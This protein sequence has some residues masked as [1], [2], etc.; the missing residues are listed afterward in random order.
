MIDL[1]S[2]TVFDKVVEAGSFTGAAERL[3]VAKAR[4]SV[5][6]SRLERALGLALFTRT[7]RQV[8]LTDAGRA[9]HEQCKPLLRGL[10]EALTE[11]GS[12]AGELSGTLR[13]SATVLHAVQSVA[14]AIASFAALHPA[15]Q[16]DLRTGDRIS[17]L[18][19]E[20][21]DLS[22]RMGWLRDS[23]QRAIKL[24]QFQQFVVASPAYLERH[25]RP[26]QPGQLASHAWI[27]L[28]LLPSPNTW[29]FEQAGGKK[30]TVHMKS[31]MLVDSPQ[32]LLQLVE[33]GAGISVLEERTLHDALRAGRLVRLLPRWQLPEGGI[34]AVLPPGRHVPARVR[35]FLDFYKNFI[36]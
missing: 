30:E 9:L 19:S 13:V 12:E 4:V 11:A 26:Q 2:L 31:R 24:G 17:D 23:S 28:S 34:Y 25:G 16:V 15:L 10:D 29:T 5:Q 33:H 6:V 14:P 36:R 20:G 8:L 32:T 7:T 27:T 22:F 1:N 21:I 3:G 18:V 35:A